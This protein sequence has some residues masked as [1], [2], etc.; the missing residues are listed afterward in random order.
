[1]PRLGLP[2][3]VRKYLSLNLLLVCAPL[4]FVASAYSWNPIAD[5][6][7]NFLAIIPLSGLISDA[8]DTLSERWGGLVGGLVNASLGNT[9]ELIVGLLAITQDNVSAAQSVMMGSILNDILLVQGICIIVG[10]RSKGVIVVN[11][12]LVDSLSSLMLVAAMAMVLPTALYAAIPRAHR[13]GAGMKE[14]IVSFSRATSIVLL[15]IYL[16]YLYFQHKTHRSLFEDGQD[17]GG[18][19]GG[20]DDEAASDHSDDLLIPASQPGSQGDEA[21]RDCESGA[22]LDS[23]PSMQDIS[24]VVVTLVLSSLAIGKCAYNIMQ[25]LDE[26]VQAFG[27]SQTFISLV[28]IPLASN[29]PEMTQVLAAAKK[30]KID[31][32]IA[33]IVGSILQIALFVLPA[34]VIIGW[35]IGSNMD[36]YFEMS[37]TCVLLFAIVLVNQVLQDRQYTYLHGMMFLCV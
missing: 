3:Q 29:A 1:M 15:L 25:R 5:F 26:T 30:Q 31:F 13:K 19:G 16:A 7:F 9:V 33:V 35:F 10:A 18:G 27:V 12:A 11:S 4:G 36:L 8:S 20:G 2:R 23:T 34:L 37:Q 14:R 21:T 32:A 24:I 17:G 6:L 22:D 28:I